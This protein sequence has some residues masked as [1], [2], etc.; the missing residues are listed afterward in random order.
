MISAGGRTND[1][2]KRVFLE[3]A[4]EFSESE[5]IALC[6]SLNGRISQLSGHLIRE[7]NRARALQQA[8][9]DDRRR[10]SGTL[11][12]ATAKLVK[13][14]IGKRLTKELTEI[15]RN[16]N[17]SPQTDN[18]IRDAL[19]AWSVSCVHYATCSLLFGLKLRTTREI[20][21]IKRSMS[22]NGVFLL[23]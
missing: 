9:R 16:A 2:A 14:V 6:R 1:V 23:S 20:E 11:N 7:K 4:D 19:D 10:A 13:K 5:L 22:T 18:S 12:K 17:T 3:K 21:E 8:K 15:N